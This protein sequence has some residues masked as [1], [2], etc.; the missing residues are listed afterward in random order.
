MRVDPDG[1]IRLPR[2]S[3]VKMK[4]IFNFDKFS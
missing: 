1:D 4:T 3:I 2:R